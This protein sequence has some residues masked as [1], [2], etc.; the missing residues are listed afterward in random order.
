[1]GEGLGGEPVVSGQPLVPLEVQRL[2]GEQD[3]RLALSA[4]VRHVEAGRRLVEHG[5][6]CPVAGP[7]D[8]LPCVVGEQKHVLVPL[9][10]ERGF[11]DR[12]RSADIGW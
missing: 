10:D 7:L 12:F 4:R 1:M 11:R 2:A 5:A 8:D 6:L 3:V 9:G